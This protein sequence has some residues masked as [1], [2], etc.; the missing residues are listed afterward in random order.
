MVILMGGTGCTGKTYLSQKLM[1]K[2]CIPYMSID[3]LKMGLIKGNANCEF[4]PLDDDE[5]IAQKMW[6]VLKG[7]ITTV[8]ENN[9][10]III[11]GCYLFPYLINQ[12]DDSYLNKIISFYI[13]FSK[14]YIEENFESKIIKYNNIIEK[15]LTE[16][17]NIREFIHNHKNI[18][19]ICKEYKTNH[20]V[21]KNNY[22]KEINSVYT[23]I[24]QQV[25]QIN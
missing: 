3:H 9:Q 25:N 4:N 23:W 24:D 22:E 1:E 19:D 14:E 18:Y 7:I 12:L 5:F 16:T 21:I 10:N 15:R 20:F 17:R 8:I 6:P 13:I 2:Y 11:E